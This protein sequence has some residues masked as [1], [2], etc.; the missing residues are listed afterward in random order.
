MIYIL[1]EG[2][3]CVGVVFLV[4][5][6]LRRP[7]L[8]SVRD[9][10]SVHGPIFQQLGCSHIRQM[11]FEKVKLI[12]FQFLIHPLLQLIP[13]RFVRRAGVHFSDACPR[14][15]VLLLHEA[16][17]STTR[18]NL[19]LTVGRLT[20]PLTCS[21]SVVV[22]AHSVVNAPILPGGASWLENRPCQ[23]AL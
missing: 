10:R 21:V 23:D 4:T 12:V 22:L 2:G 1:N 19:R 18:P 7:T 3:Q 17:V 16:L 13:R 15:E 20:L 5:W 9:H 11:N 8:C 14:N 6:L